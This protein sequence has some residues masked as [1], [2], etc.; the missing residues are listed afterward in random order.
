M[1]EKIK[2]RQEIIDRCRAEML[3]PGS[4]DVGGNIETEVI[5][6]SPKERYSLGILFP[7]G[8]FFEEND[9]E[10]QI[11]L[12][13]KEFY[14]N[15]I[16]D[17]KYQEN[18]SVQSLDDNF[19]FSEDGIQEQI[20]MTNQFLP[21]AMGFTFFAKGEIEELNVRV[22]FAKYRESSYKDC[23]VKVE[24]CNDKLIEKYL[25][26]E[27]IY[28]EKDLLRLKKNITKKI[29]H[30][31]VSDREIEKERPDIVSRL[32]KLADICT[33]DKINTGYVR[34]PILKKK[35]VNISLES[36]NNKIFINESGE[37]SVIEGVLKLNVLKKKYDQDIFS[38]TVVLVNEN[39]GSKSY[40]KCIFQPEIRVSTKDNN[41]KFIE[42]THMSKNGI[43][44]INDEDLVYELLYRNKKS[45][46]IGHGVGTGQKVD[47]FTGKGEIFTD[48]M[49]SFEVPQLEF[50]I[51]NLDNSEDILSMFELSDLST[52]N[53]D[54][55]INL[56]YEFSNAYEKWINEL[57]DSSKEI[58]SIF[59]NVVQTQIEKCK[60]ALLRMRNGI[61]VLESDKNSYDAFSLM[62]RAML[63][64]RYHS[65]FTGGDYDRYPE[66]KEFPKFDY[67]NI[68]KKNAS[69]RAF[70]LAFILMN[71]E[72]ISNPSCKD[73]DVV[74]L[75]WIPTGGGKTEA[76]LGLTGFTI[77]L[78]RLNDP[79]NGGGTAIIMRYT[80][81]LL[82]A[83][84]FVR[85]SILIC[86]C[87]KI[88]RELKQ[89]N[90]GKEEI[91]IGLWVGGTPTPNKNKEAKKLYKNLN[92]GSKKATSASELEFVKVNNNK[93]QVLKCPWCG[94]KLEI[95][96]V[97]G[98]KKGLWGYE[99]DKKKI[100]FCPDIRCDFSR[101]LPIQVVDEEIYK[102]PPTLLFG[103]VDKFAL[104]PWE[105]EVSKLFGLGD[106]DVKQPELII[107]DEL[108]LISGPLGSM[109]GLYETAI[110][111]LCSNIIGDNVIRPKI[112][113]STA[114]IK[115]ACEQCKMLFNREV[116]QF[117]PSGINI[118]DSFFI[119]E[120]P[121]E[122][123]NGRMYVGI[124]PS[125]KTPTTTQV[126][127]YT[128]LLESSK[129]INA[130]EETIDKYWTIVGY[131][132]SIRELGKTSNLIKDDIASNIVR[133]MRRLLKSDKIRYASIAQELTSRVQSTEIVKILKNLE[134]KYTE[135]VDYNHNSRPI[136][137]LLA[138]NMISVGVDVS[139]LDLMV[140]CG[141]PKQTS[142]YIQ[143]SS[144]VGRKYPGLVFTLYN[145][146]KTRDRSHY[147]LFYPYH[148]TFYK[149]VEPTS[150]TPFSEQAR[151]RG[152][153]A[154]FISMVRHLLNLRND[155]DANCF[156][157]NIE[158]LDEIEKY[159]LKR[160]QDL[161]NTELQDISKATKEELKKI[162][163][164]WNN[165]VKTSVEGD[166]VCYKSDKYN[167]NLLVPFL[168][169]NESNAFPTMQSL[170][171]VDSEAKVE[172]IV[173]GG[174][175]D[176]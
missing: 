42:H 41:I 51:Y 54:D 111:A 87:E 120:V 24:N 99:Y 64:Q 60:D 20:T 9:G 67:I 92:D 161:D 49:P 151:E 140:V 93:F 170:R 80:L 157:D 106:K 152:L 132:N 65:K 1:N 165:K 107:Q 108:H 66:D 2:I 117:P 17:I 163:E 81:R 128:V 110:D 131:F 23:C 76:Y 7:Q 5:S 102:N 112:V 113:A 62:N 123:M 95:D 43:G 171:N 115:R 142:E 130:S 138:S 156:N 58:S 34:V 148:Q 11:K 47:D 78:R 116:A 21:A 19:S 85:A 12:E 45:Y 68:D 125:G 172:I 50:T 145:Q 159:I 15:F 86:A 3:G 73:R 175:N 94:T 153:H 71:I 52:R 46:A 83:Q 160:A 59:N 25:L 18:N 26:S 40:K 155:E 38:Y 55:K 169:N 89:Y 37:V 44:I 30:E 6:D 141:Q 97:D 121:V 162:I 105:G 136:D 135:E 158:K 126:R 146:S 29:I 77:F 124:M 63:M 154:V 101:K 100:I 118:E 16:D 98:K 127:L 32:Y 22:S 173:F 31:I 176:E 90:L 133:Y 167:K 4:E 168:K 70:Q 28:I 96:Y 61:R 122:K 69:W 114:T 36:E 103:T 39:K 72:G 48:Y 144:R 129:F 14:Q 109:V 57:I 104:L 84:Q 91:S 33:V 74:D 147:E 82:A 56:L 53:K 35:L 137:V 139:R 75:I 174:E 27:Y 13:G 10:K 166:K 8:T 79:Q 149:Y 143:A 150:I 88:R 119:R 134:N 164:K